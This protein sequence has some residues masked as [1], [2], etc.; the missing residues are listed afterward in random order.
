MD[1]DKTVKMYDEAH[2]PAKLDQLS[3]S[4]TMNVGAF[5]T[6]AHHDSMGLQMRWIR[7]LGVRRVLEIGPGEGVA[8]AYLRSLGL[9][10]YTMDVTSASKPDI[11]GRLEDLDH[12]ELFKKFEL[13]CAFQ[14]LEHSPYDQFTTNLAKM[15][16]MASKYVF[17]SLPYSCVGFRFSLGFSLGQNRHWKKDF[18]FYLPLNKPNRRYRP[19]YVRDYPWAVHY[20]EIGRQGFP[21]KRVKKDIESTGLR[22]LDTFHSGNPFHFFI[23]ATN[24]P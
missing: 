16:D 23:L 3:A 5:M 13:V 1:Y 11:V 21:W 12:I 7:K 9:A 2:A 22:I 17:I 6:D 14:M 8:A 20:W 10:Y 15:S 19:E 18:S 24:Q 4:G